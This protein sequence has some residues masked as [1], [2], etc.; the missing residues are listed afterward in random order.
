MKIAVVGAGI[1]GLGAAWLLHRKHD[2]VVYER[3][4]RLGGHACT[5]DVLTP[6]ARRAVDMGFIVFNERNYPDLVAL[7]QQLGVA[8]EPSDMSFA[9]SQDDGRFEYSSSYA[10]YVAQ[11]SNL[12]R[13]SFL[14]M[15]RDILRFNRLAPRLLKKAENLDLSIGDFIKEAKLSDAF[16]DRYLVPM[17]SCIWSS[18]L[19]E[20]L[21]YPAQTFARFFDNHGLLSVGAHLRWRTVSGGSRT[22]VERIAAP[23][24]RR[25]RLGTAVVS[26]QRDRNG[27]LIRDSAGQWDRFDKVILASHAD[28][29][30]ALLADPSAL[31][32]ELL[33]CFAYCSNEVWLHADPD[34]M[35][36]RRSV[37]SSWNY[38]AANG[39]RMAKTSVT[40]WMN[41]LQNL[42]GRDLFVSV[43]PPRPPAAATVYDRRTFEHPMYD[44]AAIRA[45]RAL[46]Q[47][48]GVR[49][50]Y[51][52]G[53][54]CGYGF[55]QDALSAGLEVAEQLGVT[56]PWATPRRR[57]VL[58]IPTLLAPDPD[59]HPQPVPALARAAAEA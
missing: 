30:L 46:S 6:E 4:P 13:P 3:E 34:L 12:V 18:P 47:I 8:T 28:Q 59:L 39:D 1:A 40:Y 35:P 25:A 58:Q 15:T 33:G 36:R 14:R 19:A 7:F 41:R 51:F 55:H 21:D 24:R 17:A 11:R 45:Q 48:Q 57:G 10:G 54:Y 37:W 22:Y 38:I 5:V 32:R 53:S 29:A 31:E 43:N 23:L 44:A 52:C 50:I 27:V 26:I 42:P 16:R 9:V 49:D 2:V 56:R 20:V